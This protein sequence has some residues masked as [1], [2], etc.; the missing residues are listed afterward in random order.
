[1][2]ARLVQRSQRKQSLHAL[3]PCLA[4]ADENAARERISLAAGFVNGCQTRPG[5]CRAIGD[6]AHQVGTTAPTRSS[7]MP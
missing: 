5:P 3:E 7:M 6:A 2:P 1:M 4:D